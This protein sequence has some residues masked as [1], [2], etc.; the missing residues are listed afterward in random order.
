MESCD[1]LW[2]SPTFFGDNNS[3]F[4]ALNSWFRTNQDGV[5]WERQE[6]L[7]LT[8]VATCYNVTT[9]MLIGQVPQQQARDQ[10]TEQHGR[11]VVVA[12]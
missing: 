8:Q 4:F 10:G 12:L 7:G 11:V 9:F 6:Y 2:S 5:W 3:L 1:D